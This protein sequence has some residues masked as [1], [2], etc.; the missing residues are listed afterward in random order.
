MTMETTNLTMKMSNFSY[1]PQKF[2]TK[3]V[4]K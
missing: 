4:K 3:F 2:I 1:Q